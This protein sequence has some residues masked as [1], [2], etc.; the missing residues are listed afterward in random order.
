MS[1]RF[2]HALVM[3]AGLVTFTTASLDAKPPL[4][5]ETAKATSELKSG[6]FDWTVTRDAL[7]PLT[8]RTLWISDAVRRETL[9]GKKWVA[10]EVRRKGKLGLSI[11]R[12][13]RTYSRTK[14]A[15][16]LTSPL[17]QLIALRDVASD[18]VEDLGE[19]R[20][21]DVDS[22][23]FRMSLQNLGPDTGAEGTLSVWVDED[24]RLPLLVVQ[25]SQLYTIRMDGF[26]W[27]ITLKAELFDVEPPRDYEDTTPKAPDGKQFAQ[28]LVALKTY[29]AAY[30]HYPKVDRILGDVTSAQ[31][32][33]KLGIPTGRYTREVVGHKD[34]PSWLDASWG[35]GWINVVQ[36][37]N[38]YYGYFGKTVGP[39][40][41][42]EVLMHWKVE[43]ESYRVIYGDLKT[44]IVKAAR[45]PSLLEVK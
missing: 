36:N 21:G 40:D 39:K 11:D 3:A 14:A 4:A 16:E 22:H 9:A 32:R 6:Q 10:L 19:Q 23:G 42:G 13:S 1:N 41:A 24:S 15:H 20:I 26:Q 31:L 2:A 17:A 12:R 7:E 38:S 45:L 43:D 34:F 25:E 27:N 8:G 28:I 18:K 5:S 29:S 35:W 30:G 37:Q 33:K 44:E